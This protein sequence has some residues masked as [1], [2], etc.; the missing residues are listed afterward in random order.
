MTPDI[1]VDIGNSR[2]KWGW[3]EPMQM[4]SLPPDDEPAWDRQLAELGL[5]GKLTWAVA[6]VHPA[7]LERFA[8]WATARGDHIRV[9]THADIPLKIDVDE[10]AKVGIDRLLNALAAR[11]LTG[12]GQ[13]AVIAGVGTAVTVDL[14]TERGEFAGGVIFPGLRLMADALHRHTAL[15]P[16]VEVFPL[17]PGLPAKNTR[18]AIHAGVVWAVA[19]GIDAAVRQ[20]A[21]RCPVRPIVWVTGG[22]GALMLYGLRSD[23]EYDVRPRPTLTLEGIRLAAE[24][25]P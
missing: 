1:V 24:G 22:D 11:K 7:R 20:L 19:G 9:I 18:D 5:S 21:A 14:L 10:P 23:G 6:G 12:P 3:G 8:A 16:P 13:P 25:L 2:I 17:P 4:A 15:L